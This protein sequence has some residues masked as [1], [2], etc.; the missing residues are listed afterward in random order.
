MAGGSAGRGTTRFCLPLLVWNRCSGPRRPVSSSIRRII[1]PNPHGCALELSPDLG[2][3]LGPSSLSVHPL[4]IMASSGLS[5][6]AWGPRSASLPASGHEPSCHRWLD[7]SLNGRLTT[8]CL[9][10]G[11]SSKKTETVSLFLFFFH[12]S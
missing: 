11:L 4:S 8:V 6:S 7:K 10:T 9:P 1:L 2:P 12:L 5:G 3:D